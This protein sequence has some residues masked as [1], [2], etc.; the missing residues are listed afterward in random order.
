MLRAARIDPTE[1]QS[2]L[3]YEATHKDQNQR[4]VLDALERNPKWIG[5]LANA[6]VRVAAWIAAFTFRPVFDTHPV[7]DSIGCAP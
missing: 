4:T 5:A 1:I 2:T 6:C 3:G 7:P